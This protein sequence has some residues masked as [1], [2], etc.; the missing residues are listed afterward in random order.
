MLLPSSHGKRYA[1]VSVLSATKP[2]MDAGVHTYVS[3]ICTLTRLVSI[4]KSY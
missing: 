1:Y 3:M 2:P 4:K